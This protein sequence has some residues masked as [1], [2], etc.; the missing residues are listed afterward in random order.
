VSKE[1][2]EI[3]AKNIIKKAPIKKLLSTFIV[4]FIALFIIFGVIFGL[5]Y[6]IDFQHKK[7]VSE[8]VI[9]PTPVSAVK[10]KSLDWTPY[11]ESTGY[12]Q[13]INGVNITSQVSGIVTSINFKSGDMVKKNDVLFEIEHNRLNAQLKQKQAAMEIAQITYLRNKKLY[14]NKAVSEQQF[15]LTE[16]KYNETKAGYE[17]VQANIN[18]H[19]I[20]APFSGKLGI[21][22][23]ELGQYFKAGEAGVSLNDINPIYVNFNIVET[24]ISY[25]SVGQKINVKS[26]AY[27]NKIYE[28]EITSINSTLS[29]KTRS[30]V[31]QGTL[32]NKDTTQPLL[33]LMFT[34]V[35][36]LLAEK[37]NIITVP[38]SAINHTLYGNSIFVL[39]KS[40]TSS[41]NNSKQGEI[42]IV[43]EKMIKI[44]ASLGLDTIIIS[45]LDVNNLVV[46]SGQLKVKNNSKVIINNDIKLNN[47]N[48]QT[49]GA[50]KKIKNH[51]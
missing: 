30:L 48:M 12:I 20:K 15:D 6:F 45:G 16:A 17:E 9:N 44:G 41:P 21:R 7:K 5:R 4:G 10:A 2:N 28:G 8:R 47:K 39:Y 33:P 43:K 31:V 14:K 34:T 18:N 40:E 50:L 19:I 37:K 35:H 3:N 29:S 23:I 13:S 11:I 22:Q 25:I 49:T 32:E 27:P 36:I 1:V 42:Y 46:S 24:D 51:D 38:S 26:T